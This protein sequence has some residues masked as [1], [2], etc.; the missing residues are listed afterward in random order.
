MPALEAKEKEDLITVPAG[1]APEF[2]E[3]L[4]LRC[5]SVQA[6]KGDLGGKRRLLPTEE[7]GGNW[8]GAP[9]THSSKKTQEKNVCG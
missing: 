2:N 3:K 4:S 1:W 5:P 9:N 8:Q 7:K 6:A